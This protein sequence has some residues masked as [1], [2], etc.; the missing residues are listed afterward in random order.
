MNRKDRR[1]MD[2]VERSVT[3]KVSSRELMYLLTMRMAESGP[4]LLKAIS[5]EVGNPDGSYK[6]GHVIDVIMKASAVA[7]KAA[8]EGNAD[9]YMDACV[10][11][12]FL[13]RHL[14]V[15]QGV[16]QHHVPGGQVS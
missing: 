1:A 10:D 11:V 5:Q 7:E 8:L 16:I 14:A 3:K 2:S 13:S 15:T 9:R 4:R 6:P 12:L